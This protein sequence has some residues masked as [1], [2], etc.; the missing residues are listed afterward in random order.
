MTARGVLLSLF[1]ACVLC[2][3]AM[4]SQPHGLAAR[5]VTNPAAA[6]GVVGDN[7]LPPVACVSSFAW[8]ETFGPFQL[9]PADT[10]T[11]EMAIIP[12]RSHGT[13]VILH[14]AV[15]KE[16]FAELRFSDGLVK[17]VPYDRSGWNDVS[18]Q[19]R[20][21]TQD[22]TI[23]VNGVTGG[24]F[25]YESACQQ[26]GG[27]FTLRA[28]SLRGNAEVEGSVAWIDSVSLSRESAAGREAFRE[29][30][31]DFP[32]AALYLTTGGLLIS[33]P[34]QRTRTRR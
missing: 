15:R 9:D 16:A 20:P 4:A 10:V 24:P 6:G 17:G 32:C 31:F 30:T 13:Q 1:V 21:A 33:E 28:F 29:V 3:P 11:L 34:P 19:L 2:L 7:G 5:F 25:A 8:V 26:Q 22:Y 27:C 23:T 12:L 18:V 14:E